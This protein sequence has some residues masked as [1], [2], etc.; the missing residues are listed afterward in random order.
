MKKIGL[1]ISP[2]IRTN[3]KMSNPNKMIYDQDIIQ[4]TQ[5]LKYNKISSYIIYPEFDE[6]GR[7]HYHG[8]LNLDN[9]QYI[10]YHKHAIHKFRQIG[11]V[12]S[13][14]IKT[15]IDSLR[16][17]TYISKNWLTTKE[18]LEIIHPIMPHTTSR[19]YRIK[20]AAPAPPPHPTIFDFMSIYIQTSS[21][22]SEEEAGKDRREVKK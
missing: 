12:D 6:K 14:L 3:N 17:L 9:N 20:P 22:E 21:K 15:H 19:Q 11:F 13:K 5:I 18:I 1:T 8:K 16:W 7:L 10:R 4:I 2:P